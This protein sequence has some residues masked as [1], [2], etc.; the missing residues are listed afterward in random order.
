V[1][2]TSLSE[3]S[4]GLTGVLGDL[5]VNE[6]DDIESDWGSADGRESNLADDLLGVL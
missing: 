1:L 3:D 4:V 6:L 5:I 2:H